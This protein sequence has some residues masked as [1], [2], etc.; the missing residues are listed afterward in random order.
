MNP[1][2]CVWF[3]FITFRIKLSSATPRYLD[4]RKGVSLTLF[5]V[6]PLTRNSTWVIL[7]RHTVM[8][9]LSDH[10]LWCMPWSH[11]THYLWSAGWWFKWFILFGLKANCHGWAGCYCCYS[12]DIGQ[13]QHGRKMCN[14]N[15]RLKHYEKVGNMRLN[16]R[17]L[18][19][20]FPKTLAE[21]VLLCI[22]WNH[23][24][25][26]SKL[27]QYLPSYQYVQ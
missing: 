17:L 10:K 4:T 24:M 16:V 27:I 14:I 19:F 8:N 6:A 11:P 18:D 12:I 15:V 3:N 25:W 20:Y 1:S 9:G 21:H 23:I 26:C 22:I 7:G 2:S 5:T 13:L